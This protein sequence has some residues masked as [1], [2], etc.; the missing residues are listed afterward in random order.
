MKY[1]F[2]WQNRHG[3]SF[4]EM[5]GQQNFCLAGEMN[6]HVLTPDHGWESLYSAYYKHYFLWIFLL[7]VLIISHVLMP[8]LMSISYGILR[9][10]APMRNTAQLIFII[11]FSLLQVTLYTERHLPL[12]YK[13]CILKVQ[14]SPVTE[15]QIYNLQSP[16][17]TN[18]L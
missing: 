17:R 9:N 12:Y 10:K 5:F 2:E 18:R 15:L 7:L 16:K 6:Q 8:W 13:Q 3:V 4:G 1:K 14:Q 11:L